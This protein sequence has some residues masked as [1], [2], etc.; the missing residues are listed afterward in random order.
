MIKFLK[1]IL[2]LILISL[3]LNS[4][5]A[6]EYG[7]VQ[8]D[9]IIL[10]LPAE[11]EG[12]PVVYVIP[13]LTQ[14][15]NFSCGYR[16]IFHALGIEKSLKSKNFDTSLEKM[17]QNVDALHKVYSTYGV[18]DALSNYELLDIATHFGIADKL[19]FMC[20]DKN[21][22]C[23]ID[24]NC[25]KMGSVK[26][27]KKLSNAFI[28]KLKNTLTKP[29]TALHVICNPGDHWMLMSIVRDKNNN[30]KLYIID[31]F[32]KPLLKE[33]MLFINFFLE[34]INK[35]ELVA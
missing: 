31:S 22:F 28:K 27:S 35:L 17:L 4:Q 6:I 9:N 24:G 19:V 13:L 14:E 34:N 21:K 1:L 10:P 29:S 26:K 8:T 23:Y 2:S 32:I 15:D 16:S 3:G 33:N 30:I 25:P 20:L 18:D 11:L 7:L 12:K 5:A